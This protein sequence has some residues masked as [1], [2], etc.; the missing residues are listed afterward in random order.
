MSLTRRIAAVVLVLVFSGALAADFLAR[1]PYEAQ[2]RN[3]LSAAPSWRYP[4]GTDELGRDRLSRL[5]HG[6]RVSLLLAPAAA[7]LSLAISAFMGILAGYWGGWLERLMLAG[8]D[9]VLSLPWLFLMLTVRATLPLNVSPALSVIITFALLGTLGWGPA[10]RVVHAGV[11]SFE[12]SEFVLQARAG[13]GSSWK[14][15]SVHILPNLKPI[16][17]AQFWIL[18]PAFLLSEANLGL[19]GLGVAEPLPSLGSLLREM[20]NLNALAASP[21]LLAPATLLL[22]V[23]SCFHLVIPQQEALV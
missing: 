5:L 17:F 16:L 10:A 4:L 18:V 19:L 20:E 13:G 21:W 7:L 11:R 9:L 6:A 15:M 14:V 22:I 2:D 12:R 8:T 3:Q 23:V 1:T